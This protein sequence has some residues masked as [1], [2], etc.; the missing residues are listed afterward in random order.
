MKT[1]IIAI[2]IVIATQTSCTLFTDC[3]EGNGNMK[4]ESRDAVPF[5]AIANEASFHVVYIEGDEYTITVEAESNILPY[6]ET[7][8]KRGALG[9][10]TISGTPCLR[11]N[12]QPVITVTAPSIREL[13]NSGSGGIVSGDL[14]GE[15]VRLV[16]SGSGDIIAGEISASETSIVTSGSGNIMTDDIASNTLKATLAGSGDLTMSGR[17]ATNK[18][19]VSGSG[20]IFSKELVTDNA[21]VTMTGS[22]KVYTNVKD[23]LDLVISGSGNL[24]LLGNPSVN[25]TRSGSGQIIH[26]Q[27]IQ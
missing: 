26:L 25:I 20:S 11:Y 17:T 1:G 12:T 22:G 9:I 2:I 19:A 10:G 15:E 4:T 14:S 23:H 8:I 13:V 7:E 21:T 24:Y 5:T 6:I 3:V 16:A 18:Y 27:K